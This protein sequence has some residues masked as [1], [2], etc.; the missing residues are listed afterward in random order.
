MDDNSQPGCLEDSIRHS[1]SFGPA[2]SDKEEEEESYDTEEYA[3]EEGE[4]REKGEGEEGGI[5]LSD[6]FPSELLQQIFKL[7]PLK[8]LLAVGQVRSYK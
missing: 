1:G 2:G 4:V 5:C 3:Q 7:L 6:N 8:S